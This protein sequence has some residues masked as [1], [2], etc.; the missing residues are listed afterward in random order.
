MNI[1]EIIEDLKN[2]PVEKNGELYHPIPFPEF[3]GLTTSSKPKGVFEKWDIISKTV[4]IIFG[5][6]KDFRVL[7]VGANAGFYTFNFAKDGAIVKSF[8]C[9]DRYKNIG[10]VIAKEKNLPVEWN[11]IAFRS[12]SIQKEEQFDLALLLSVYQWMA[13]GNVNDKEAKSSLKLISDQSDYLFFELGYNS[14]KSCVRT[15]KWFHYAE[16]IRFLQESTSYTN[17]KLVGKTRLWGGRKRYLILCSNNPKMEDKGWPAFLRK[18][19]F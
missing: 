18:F 5:E 6:K 16:M 15:N 17:F 1:E 9:H 11:P 2:N 10:G 3:D 7:D 12:N 4:K 19:K 14:G 8:E 13:N